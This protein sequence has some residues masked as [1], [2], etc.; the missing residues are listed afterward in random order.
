MKLDPKLLLS[1]RNAVT[2][3]VEE[4]KEWLTSGLGNLESI[5]CLGTKH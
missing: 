5:H 2:K 1:K 4:L 3:M